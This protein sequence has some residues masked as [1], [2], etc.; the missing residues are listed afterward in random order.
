MEIIV[1][2][3]DGKI[4]AVSGEDLLIAKLSVSDNAKVKFLG[5]GRI[6]FVTKNSDGEI[7][8]LKPGFNNELGVSLEKLIEAN[9]NDFFNG[10]DKSESSPISY[11]ELAHV[12]RNLLLNSL[13]NQ[14][15]LISII[16]DAV[17]SSGFS[18]SGPTDSRAAEDGEPIWV[19]KGRAAIGQHS[20]IKI[21]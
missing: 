14:S 6:L 10:K 4:V 5:S 19:C 3:V 9:V 17:T 11:G 12:M 15:N 2:K 8:E 7:V 20:A 18:L 16:E 21:D 13:E 1:R